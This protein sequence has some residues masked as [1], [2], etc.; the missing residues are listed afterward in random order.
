MRIVILSDS[1]MVGGAAVACRRL[2]HG[3]TAIGEDVVQI[4][5]RRAGKESP[6]WEIVELTCGPC[7]AIQANIAKW[8]GAG[9]LP[10]TLRRKG[11][12]DRLPRLLAGLRPD[13]INIHNLHGE[14]WPPQ[15]AATCRKIAPVVWTMHDMWSFTGRCAT[16]WN[17][18]KFI[19]GCDA[20]CP[21]PN[22]YPELAP[23]K[24]GPAW[25]TRRRMMADLPDLVGITPS[26]WLAG[27][28]RLGI[29][30]S[31]RVEVIPNGLPLGLFCP[32]DQREARRELGLPEAQPAFLMT[33]TT[34]S[35]PCKGSHLVNEMLVHLKRRPITCLT[36]G[37]KPPSSQI[38]GIDF[39]HLGFVKDDRIKVLAYSA[40]DIFLHPA[41]YDN[42]P[43]TIMEAMAC[44][45]PA[46]AF[47]VGGIPDLVRENVTGWLADE[48]SA[49]SLAE[50]LD[51][52]LSMLLDCKET[53]RTQC[54]K[55]AES[56]YGDELQALRYK[57]LFHELTVKTGPDK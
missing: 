31:N 38:P 47:P 54:R 24:I 26:R 11:S 41:T 5:P 39:I 4:V 51:Y 42:L 25:E 17:C 29:W 18:D 32:S 13:L 30:K 57:S 14:G 28:A 55:V 34:F 19:T 50:K 52:A 35:D 37:K 46:V 43:N 15:I 21:T 3:L 45:T 48:V 53:F 56:E 33:A 12:L 36:M 2:A 10:A 22:E 6:G 9:T 8:L 23:D 44:G 40:A 16:Y 20:A 1:E 7:R 49:L 27:K